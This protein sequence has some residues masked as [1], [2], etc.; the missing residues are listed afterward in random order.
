MNKEEGILELIRIRVKEIAEKEQMLQVNVT[1]L[2]KPLTPEE[3]IGKPGRRDFPII[4][5]KERVMEATLQGSKGHAFT[6]SPQEFLGTLNDVLNL[7]LTTNQ[8]RAIYAAT[9]N[10]LLGSLKIVEK[11]VHCKD[12]EPEECALE[13]AE[14]I[15]KKYGKVNVGLI[16]L[17]PAIAERLI[18]TFGHEHVRIT[19]L[20]RDI[21]GEQ[22][23][24]VEIWDGNVRTEELIDKSDI[25]IFTGTTLVNNTFSQ[26][27]NRIQALG[28]NYLVYGVTSAA[29]SE[30]LGIE[31][32]CPKGRNS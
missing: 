6:D 7:D 22:R 29:V 16:G 30:L 9:I 1:V 31:R 19:D 28:K 14:M 23:F 3:A 20:G 11:T 15:L 21:I 5:G 32:I 17:N 2:A 12:D 25:I 27:K 26:I 10:A 8:N 24:G 18:D 13:I 4:I